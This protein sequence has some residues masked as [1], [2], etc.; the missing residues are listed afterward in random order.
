MFRQLMFQIL[1]F[2][3]SEILMIGYL[4]GLFAGYNWNVV[5]SN[6]LRICHMHTKFNIPLCLDTI[7]DYHVL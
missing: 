6:I 4:M 7:A 5:D 1:N 2:K 3:S